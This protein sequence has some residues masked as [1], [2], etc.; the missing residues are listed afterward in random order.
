MIVNVTVSIRIPLIDNN[1]PFQNISFAH[2]TAVLRDG[3][4]TNGSHVVPLSADSI[5]SSLVAAP[6]IGG[7]GEIY[8]QTPGV[9]ERGSLLAR[10]F[11]DESEPC[12]AG[13]GI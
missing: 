2:C 4:P 13:T 5:D 6:R 3:K 7:Q 1:Y 11:T 12:S 9:D 10:I 8:V